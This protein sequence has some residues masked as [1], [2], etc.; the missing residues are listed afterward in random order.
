MKIRTYP[1]N[2]MYAG[3]PEQVVQK[4]TND[5]IFF[6]VKKSEDYMRKVAE[7]LPSIRLN[8]R[9]NEERCKSFLKNLLRIG[10][11]EIIAGKI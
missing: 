11:I 3:T 7:H 10:V 9:T 1:E 4:M 2:K 5:A 6:N 8:G